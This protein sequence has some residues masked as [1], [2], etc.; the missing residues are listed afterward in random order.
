MPN[1]SVSSRRRH[2]LIRQLRAAH[3]S[4]STWESSVRVAASTIASGEAAQQ[5]AE[6]LALLSEARVSVDRRLAE[7]AGNDSGFAFEHDHALATP[8]QPTPKMRSRF[9]DPATALYHLCVRACRVC[10]QTLGA[11]FREAQA[12][13]DAASA[14]VLYVS[15]R[16]FEKQIWMLDPAHAAD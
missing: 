15:L 6:L 4:L 14:K 12:V 13:A 11:A 7:L 10:G 9:R 2:R 1:T 3:V 16:D 8:L 5:A